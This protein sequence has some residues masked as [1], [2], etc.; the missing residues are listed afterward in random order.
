M[1]SCMLRIV[2]QLTHVTIAAMTG[3]KRRSCRANM[4][5]QAAK[6]SMNAVNIR[7]SV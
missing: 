7:I 5:A 6:K 4:L 3:L 1:F 2:T